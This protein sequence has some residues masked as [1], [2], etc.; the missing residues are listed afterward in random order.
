MNEQTLSILKTAV[1]IGVTALFPTI[2]VGL[3][4]AALIGYKRGI[5]RVTYNVLMLC[6]FYLTAFL[7]LDPLIKTLFNWDLG[8]TGYHTVIVKNAETGNVYY[9][10]VTTLYETAKSVVEGFYLL[11]NINATP[12][13]AVNFAFAITG[14]VL[15]LVIIIIDVLL[16]TLF[17]WLISLLLWHIAFKRLVPKIAMKVTRYKWI[18]M[19]VNMV[20]YLV[21]AFMFM[22]PL[23]SL[24]NSINQTY[25]RSKKESEIPQNEVI[26]TIG[27]FLDSYNNSLFAQAFFN[28]TYNEKTGLTWDAKFVADLTTFSFN[29]NKISV[30]GELTSLLSSTG[31]II[32]MLSIDEEG[33]INGV[34]LEVALAPKTIEALFNIIKRSGLISA[35]LPLATDI[36]LNSDVLNEY[37][38]ARRIGSG[39]INWSKE[40]DNIEDT[41]IEF[42]ESGL[43]DILVEKDESGKTVF[44]KLNGAQVI[45]DILKVDENGNSSDVFA[46]TINA[47]RNI[48][49]SNLLS[50][51]IPVAMMSLVTNAGE[52][53]AQFLPSTWEE[54]SDISWG[55]EL[56]TLLNILHNLY[57]VDV[58]G[59][60]KMVDYMF[61]AD[62]EDS[63]DIAAK[64]KYANA[65][66][67]GLPTE[68]FDFL[69]NKLD[70]V[71]EVLFGKC[72]S[73]GNP[74]GVDKYG[75]TI[76]Y[77][78]GSKKNDASYN[79][80][81]MKLTKK[82][83]KPLLNLLAGSLN[84]DE[85]R[86]EYLDNAIN[87]LTSGNDWMR[88]YKKE[89]H[90]IFNVVRAFTDNEECKQAI[91]DLINGKSI[92][93]EN[94]SIFSI[95]N[96]L[97]D[98]LV[99]ALQRLDK[100]ELVY[101]LFVPML[102]DMVL[103]NSSSLTDI[104][105]DID[106]IKGGFDECFDKRIFGSELAKLLAKFK[107]IG[108]II[109]G[110]MNKS[111]PTE[112]IKTIAD[113]YLKLASLLDTFAECKILNPS[114]V[115]GKFK[116]NGNYLNVIAFLFDQ[117]NVDGFSFDVNDPQFESI[118]WVNEY[119]AD[120]TIKRKADGSFYGENGNFAYVIKTIADTNI[121]TSLKDL[122]GSS[123]E[124]SQGEIFGSI[125][126]DIE[127]VFKSVDKS[128]II[129]STLAPM[130][131]AA[132]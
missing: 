64:P 73:D 66:G 2:L 31:T 82:L 7:T 30:P 113:N 27:G 76:V 32:N 117:I 102:E 41:L 61:N 59:A 39:N 44:K 5:W 118:V 123:S 36:A 95:S 33:K 104:G 97:I 78:N 45:K 35:A 18:S 63:Q 124:K 53:V 85:K 23:T 84:L 72:D 52:E 17:G 28:W 100:S 116:K 93:G 34:D 51:A 60:E 121:L 62:G 54:L 55:F 38:E 20:K 68:V 16:I 48:D 131:D 115:E 106:Y 58:E 130:M 105:L 47:L 74:T 112:A 46:A 98:A 4:L 125:A 92:V 101:G 126:D 24:V 94:E 12:A 90:C 13:S 99:V 107:D 22:S 111:D 109:E 71:I 87:N 26:E 77:E 50:N 56:S 29:G 19:A 21:I 6:I 57:L 128:V 96:V 37:F 80:F 103:N 132:V 65:E 110:A 15:K 14:S 122:T 79:L 88:K 119:N 67:E 8:F 43:V 89:F 3:L 10:P 75:R 42:A 120:G 129:R 69:L 25:Q 83:L 40:I 91:K 11:Y 70:A 49:N 81:D 114:P 108:E 127:T 9:A 1:D 86:Q